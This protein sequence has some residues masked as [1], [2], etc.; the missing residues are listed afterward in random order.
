MSDSSANR[1]H[2][3]ILSYKPC[4]VSEVHPERRSWL[5][6]IVTS[7]RVESVPFAYARAK[8]KV[9]HGYRLPS[10]MQRQ[11]LLLLIFSPSKNAQKTNTKFRRAP[12]DQYVY[13]NQQ[14]TPSFLTGPQLLPPTCG[15]LQSQSC[16]RYTNPQ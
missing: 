2:T 5:T 8:R 3:P 1:D 7:G 9:D 13:G 12:P 16:Y 11:S 10:Y 4:Q 15:L 14:A 6:G